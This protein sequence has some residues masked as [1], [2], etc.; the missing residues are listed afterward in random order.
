MTSSGW[1]HFDN[2]NVT[3]IGEHLENS[4]ADDLTFGD[5]AKPL[6]GSK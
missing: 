5:G 2:V 4:K 1:F 6:T 3:P